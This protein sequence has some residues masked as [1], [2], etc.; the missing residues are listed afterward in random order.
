MIYAEIWFD[1]LQINLWTFVM[2]TTQILPRNLL[3]ACFVYL[4]NVKVKVGTEESDLV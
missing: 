4:F 3:V 2:A 1:K